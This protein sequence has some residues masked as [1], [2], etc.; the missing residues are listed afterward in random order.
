[1]RL[2]DRTKKPD[3]DPE[4]EEQLPS[5]RKRTAEEFGGDFRHHKAD[6]FEE[7]RLEKMLD[8]QKDEDE[9][10]NDIGDDTE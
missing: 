8:D 7:Q 4:P 5:R 1:M 3:H 9:H 2:R 10:D 6:Y